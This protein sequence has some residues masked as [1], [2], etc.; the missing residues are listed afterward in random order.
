MR[1]TCVV[2]GKCTEVGREG[3]P[4]PTAEAIGGGG[5]RMDVSKHNRETCYAVREGDGDNLG[6]G[7]GVRS[8]VNKKV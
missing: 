1:G 8:M 5:K 6:N 3:L 7:P 4:W 2:G